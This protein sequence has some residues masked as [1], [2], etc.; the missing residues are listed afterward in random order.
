[1]E[2]TKWANLS[3]LEKGVVVVM[4]LFAVAIICLALIAK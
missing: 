4:A 2:T 1:M 3:R